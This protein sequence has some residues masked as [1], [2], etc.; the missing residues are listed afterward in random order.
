M[1]LLVLKIEHIFNSLIF[2]D[3]FDVL[4]LYERTLLSWL[5]RNFIVSSYAFKMPVCSHCEFLHCSTILVVSTGVIRASGRSC[6]GDICCDESDARCRERRAS[7]SAVGQTCDRCGERFN[8]VTGI[9]KQK[10]HKAFNSP[11]VCIR[12]V[13]LRFFIVC[14]LY[15]YKMLNACSRYQQKTHRERGGWRGS[16]IQLFM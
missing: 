14:L 9:M 4:F 5:F 2:N 3:I 15:V 7:G 11:V 1:G 8:A 12:C 10:G 16:K 13:S 6:G